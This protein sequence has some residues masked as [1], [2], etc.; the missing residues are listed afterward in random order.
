MVRVRSASKDPQAPETLGRLE[1][2]R[3]PRMPKKQL[4]YAPCMGWPAALPIEAPSPT[5]EHWRIRD[6]GS[7]HHGRARSLE[8]WVRGG[9]LSCPALAF[10]QGY[11]GK[12]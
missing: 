1:A 3:K 12:Q 9:Q 2:A 6:D 8:S 10:A 7:S 5:S 11:Q 4:G